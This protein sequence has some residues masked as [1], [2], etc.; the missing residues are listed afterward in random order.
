[1]ESNKRWEMESTMKYLRIKVAAGVVVALVVLTSLAHAQQSSLT[2]DQAVQRLA[3]FRVGGGREPFIE[4]METLRNDLQTQGSPEIYWRLLE[5][6]VDPARPY[7]VRMSI[8]AACMDFANDATAPVVLDYLL[9]WNKKGTDERTLQDPSP[10]MSGMALG[11]ALRR[12]NTDSEPWEKWIERDARTSQIVR[13]LGML[14]YLETIAMPEADRRAIALD[15]VK[16][17]PHGGVVSP[18]VRRVLDNPEGRKA[19]L[20]ILRNSGTTLMTI[21]HS[22]AGTLAYLGDLAARDYLL[23]IRE[24]FENTLDVASD[25]PVAARRAEL[26]QGWMRLWIAKV[27]VQQSTERLMATIEDPSTEEQSIPLR[28]FAVE[29]AVELGVPRERVHEALLRFGVA[30]EA[31]LAQLPNPDERRKRA[32]QLLNI[33]ESAKRLELLNDSDWAFLGKYIDFDWMDQMRKHVTW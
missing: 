7:E 10:S 6:A 27:N 11:D 16:R 8:V 13:S 9:L 22:A 15:Y 18:Q 19:M 12:R 4:A 14:D 25:N 2:L 26:A 17:S 23:S 29:R 24:R 1:M 3:N 21:N 30:A 5:A 33:K 28:R 31:S 32:F 20:E